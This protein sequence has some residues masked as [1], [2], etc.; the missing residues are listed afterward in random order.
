[1]HGMA[2][3]VDV[4]RHINLQNEIHILLEGSCRAD[5]DDMEYIL[6]G[7]K[8]LVIPKNKYH[9]I[10]GQDGDFLHFTVAFELYRKGVE[11]IPEFAEISITPKDVELCYDIIKESG[12]PSPFC[13]QRIFSM[14]TLLLT[15]VFAK[16]PIFDTAQQDYDGSRFDDRYFIIDD[17][18]ESN[19]GEKC[20]EKDLADRL[21]V[22]AR[23]LNRILVSNYGENFRQK[24]AGAR[25]DRAKWLLRT[26]DM[27]IAD[28]SLLV[29][30]DSPTSFYKAFK[31]GCGT[32]PST[33]RKK[34]ARKKRSN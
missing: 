19:I 31:K 29:G 14:Y 22:S 10:F 17:F 33:Y 18:F 21:H 7:D 24:L 2:H 32:T 3:G 20:T 4:E 6:S 11:I 5:I 16:L 23:Q 13:H 27:S 25:T 1:M 26:S 15:S 8:A 28:I 12:N 30:F 34:T 9:S